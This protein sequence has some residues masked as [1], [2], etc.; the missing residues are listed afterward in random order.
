MMRMTK[1]VRRLRRRLSAG[2]TAEQVIALAAA[3]VLLLLVLTMRCSGEIT[4]KS[5]AEQLREA[6]FVTKDWE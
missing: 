5:G 6:V 3:S 4:G 2:L 1:H